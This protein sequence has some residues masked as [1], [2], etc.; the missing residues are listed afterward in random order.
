MGKAILLADLFKESVDLLTQNSQEWMG[1]LSTVAKYYKMS[2][3]KCVLIHVQRPDA[4]LLATKMGWERNTGRYLRAGSKGIGVVDMDNP[5]ATLTYYFD[6][7]DTRGDYDSFKKAMRLVWELEKQYQP[8]ILK[9]F[10]ETF[11]TD[12]EHIQNCLC[13]LVHLQAKAYFAIYPVELDL[14][15]PDSVVH[16]LP[17]EAV[18]EDIKRLIVESAAYIVL[19]KC[20]IDTDIFEEA[21][22]F[23]NISHFCFLE[24]FMSI[25]YHAAMMARPI[26]REVHRQIE[27]IKEERGQLYEGINSKPA[28]QQ[29]GGRDDVSTDDDIIQER[30][31]HEGHREIRPDMEGVPVGEA[32]PE[33]GNADSNRKDQREDLPDT[34]KSRTGKGEDIPETAKR[35]SDARNRE[36]VGKGWPYGDAVQHGRGTDDRK[37]NIPVPLKDDNGAPDSDIIEPGVPFDLDKL[38]ILADAFQKVLRLYPQE[39]SDAVQYIIL[40][41]ADRKEKSEEIAELF[42]TF[43]KRTDQDGNGL[44]PQEKKVILKLAGGEIVIAYWEN[45]LSVAEKIISDTDRTEQDEKGRT[46]EVEEIKGQIS[47]FGSDP[48]SEENDQ[49]M[50]L[51]ELDFTIRELK[52]TDVRQDESDE[53][54]EKESLPPVSSDFSEESASG[55]Y[56]IPENTYYENGP[57]AK[58][59]G[60]LEAIKL[61]KQLMEEGR[62]ATEE[63][64]R[65]LVK[66]VGWGGLADALTPGKKGWESEYALLEEVLSPEEYTAA[67]AS[68]L[69][70]YYTDPMIIRQ[71]YKALNQ[72]GFS[73]GNILDPAAGTGN[74]LSAIPE[75]MSAS[76]LFGVEIEPIAGNIA[77]LLHPEADIQIKGFEDTAFSD[78]FFDVIVG[79]IP[80][81]AY[82]VNDR[83]Y[84]RYHFRIHDYFIAKSLDLVRPGGIIAVIT[85]MYTM[86]KKNQ[87][88][89]KYIA[90]RAELIGAVRLPDNAFKTI[91]GTEVTTDILFL[92]KR[93]EEWIPD[94]N[95]TS[96]LSVEKDENN[97]P[98]NRYFID[99]PE[100][101]L[102]TLVQEQGMY[103]KGDAVTCKAWKDS[104][105]EDLL[106]EALGRLHAVYEKP[107]S[108]LED[109]NETK[110]EEMIPARPEVRNYCY[111]NING[112]LYYREN[113]SMYLQDIGGKKE[114]RIKG[115]LEVRTALRELMDF[116]LAFEAE[117]SL[118]YHVQLQQR[119][120]NLNHSYDRFIKQYGFINSRANIMALA[121]DNEAPLLRSIEDPMKDER[122][123]IKKGEYQK[124]AVFFKATI[125]PWKMPEQADTV[126]DALRISLT[127][128]GK[129][130]LD[131][132]QYLYRNG[133]AACSK[134]TIL[135]ELGVK[136]YQDPDGYEAG[137][138]YSG[139]ILAE[140]YL[141]GNVKRKLERA[142]LAAEEEPDRFTRN[143]KALEAVQP[144]PLS[145]ED[146]GFSLGSTW[147]PVNIYEDFM[148]EKLKTS[149]REIHVEFSPYAGSY[150]ISG[151]SWEKD[152]VPVNTT[153]GTQRM[154]AY[155]ILE[156]TL[157]LHS[158]QV[159]DRV[160]YME[161]GKDKVKYVL[162]RKE[163]LL[164]REKQAQLQME[165]STWLFQDPIRG[166]ML[167]AYYND[168]FNTIRSR[169]FHGDDLILPDLNETIK[170][171]KNQLDVIAKGLYSGKNLLNAQDV[172]AGKTMSTCVIIH[173]RKRLGLC[174][175]PM[176]AVP[177]HTLGQWATEYLRL[178]PNANILVATKK[179]LEKK[180]RQRFISRV[181][182][183]DYECIIIPH[184]S[185][186]KIAIS[187]SR[188]LES[189]ER[190][191]DEIE[192]MIQ[193]QK[194]ISGK[195]WSL[196]QMEL[197][198]KNLQA[199][200]DNLYNADKK[201][202]LIDFEEL[203]VDNLIVDEAHIYKNDYVY[204]KMDNVAGLIGK[205]SQR[206]M[207]MRMKCHYINE[208]TNESGI[209]FLTATPITNSMA[210]LYVMQ[211]IL[212]PSEL[213]QRGILAFDNWASTF[214][215]VTTSLEIK[216]EGSGYQMKTRFSSFYNL[217]ELINILNLV[218]DI[219]TSDMLDIPTPELETGAMQVIKTDITSEQEE[220]MEELVDRAEEIRKGNVDSSQDN[221]LRLT[222]EARLLAVDPR[223]LDNTLPYNPNTKLVRCAE[224]AVEI[225]SKTEGKKSTQLI[226]CDKGT[227]RND[228]NFDFYHALKKELIE[229]GVPQEQIC[230]IHQIKT[231]DQ[232]AEIF[233]R[234]RCG[235]IRILIGS[236]EKMGTGMNVQDKVIGLHHL[237]T[238]WRPSDLT[239]RNGR[240]LR[241]GNENE[242]IAIYVYITEKTFDAYL[243]QILEQ[244]QRYISQI[245]TGRSA[246]RSC[247]DIDETVLQYAEFKAMA[248]SDPLIKRKMEVDNEVYRLQ[249][250]KAAWMADRNSLQFKVNTAFPE[251]IEKCRLL[252]QKAEEDYLSYKKN[253]QEGFYITI[254]HR[255]FEERKEAGEYLQRLILTFEGKEEGVS[256]GSYAGLQIKVKRRPF[257]D[258]QISLV[259]KGKYSAYLGDSAVG[260][261]KRLE[262]LADSIS[263]VKLENEERLKKLSIQLQAAKEELAKPFAMEGELASLL[264]EQVSLNLKIEFND[265]KGGDEE[266]NQ[267][268]SR[269]VSNREKRLYRKMKKLAPALFDGSYFFMKFQASSDA[270]EPLILQ[271]V[272]E[273]IYSI[274]HTYVKNGD[275]MHDPEITFQVLPEESAVIPMSYLQEDMGIYYETAEVPESR[276]KDLEMFWD[277]TWLPNI[278][279]TNYRLTYARGEE[280]EFFEETEEE[281]VL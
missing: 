161:E 93:Q 108:V 168:R 231:D 220:L 64:Q 217:P 156:D 145:P 89:R 2:F 204:T 19:K 261:M 124:G 276:K 130:D 257:E 38:E 279:S 20:G 199:K 3:D 263:E 36:P 174:N 260:N 221:F 106:E 32:S 48:F 184:S 103:G 160:D 205:G 165:F 244:K 233:D 51:T 126:D 39:V 49:D 78:N 188:Q 252:A 238:P 253:K 159:R 72:F 101:V 25:G 277:D 119:L 70:A 105:L 82:T 128:H 65:T 274:A 67:S 250:V 50:I 131:Y 135:E 275:V 224:N 208:I 163:T 81:S 76:Q 141:S 228:G 267:E 158:V 157:N 207:D 173:D 55:F 114:E 111:A 235:E 229:R 256:V 113:S 191:I 262:N 99:H 200:Y 254:N 4:G 201:D 23:A 90:Q 273:D 35:E 17:H 77:K 43:G 222:N 240:G 195:S 107:V 59:R 132:M 61:C 185:F 56:F 127:V 79:N 225:F 147:I 246:A 237:D 193:E 94:E 139:W 104:R 143:V 172:G 219:K 74:F 151:K 153:Y 175:K 41:K 96:W 196:K 120:N 155:E 239:Q 215:R 166:R 54:L 178:Y 190:E 115:M 203:G 84:A 266:E 162:N 110:L 27:I 11:Q 86:D 171:R 122:G 186:E 40:E 71:I 230:F 15:D 245:L 118:A 16:A 83:R 164:A 138:P 37:S 45:L 249:T 57:K 227:P 87:S 66:Y 272:E 177:N 44:E 211:R 182:T 142:V 223:I 214:G 73:S 95:N 167:T 24:G 10:H 281:A 179:D 117:E 33:V 248:V 189:V 14:K 140:E 180:H 170:L 68:V 97:I 258:W 226:F 242:V 100:M 218:A 18:T 255:T 232:R 13:Q 6:I 12:G 236:T 268:L 176:I 247:E 280:E 58:C 148:Y 85:S 216:P 80:F 197:Y 47:L 264:K 209:V 149:N 91:A 150:H 29:R 98:C 121:K 88:I 169:I 42:L 60:N 198:R 134:E 5:Q 53:S 181:A 136:A 8:A 28:V 123:T 187:R 212:Q 22:A 269:P 112:R 270:F 30:V 129:L 183:G 21:G 46:T 152:S 7:A 144:E 102:G 133:N 31:R 137:D 125:Q 243:F 154:N 75:E 9:Y 1:L 192:A 109:D 234:V 202:D 259:G 278:F 69:T 34:G 62:N 194:D 52:K 26:L 271:K 92:K 213:N 63:E 206:A 146:I 210:E 116:Q 241:Q 265:G 251:K